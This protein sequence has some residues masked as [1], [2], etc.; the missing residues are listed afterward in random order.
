MSYRQERFEKAAKD[1]TILKQR[2]DQ[3]EMGEVY[4]LYKQATVGD[5]NTEG[6]AFY[7]FVAKAKWM[8]WDKKKGM[9]KEEAMSAYIGLVE[10]LKEKYGIE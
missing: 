3:T 9:S 1:V 4:S 7:D 8:A 10:E 6:P 5:N 2:P